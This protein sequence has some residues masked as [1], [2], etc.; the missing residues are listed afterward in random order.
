MK[1]K[2]WIEGHPLFLFTLFIQVF[3]LIGI[4]CGFAA[5][6]MNTFASEDKWIWVFCFDLPL[7]AFILWVW[8]KA[9]IPWTFKIVDDEDKKYKENGERI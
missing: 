4:I 1:A 8:F 5:L 3:A 6:F 9:I 2:N 7:L